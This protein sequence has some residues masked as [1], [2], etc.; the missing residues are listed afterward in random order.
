MTAMP[1]QSTICRMT[2]FGQGMNRAKRTIA[3]PATKN[4]R[5]LANQP[6]N[7]PTLKDWQKCPPIDQGYISRISPLVFW[8][9][10]PAGRFSTSSPVRSMVVVDVRSVFRIGRPRLNSVRGSSGLPAPWGVR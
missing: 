3:N 6:T 2:P 7:T 1:S 8:P 5:P 4:H 10:T 9:G